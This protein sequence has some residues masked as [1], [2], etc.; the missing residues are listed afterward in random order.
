MVCVYSVR[1]TS[2]RD[3]NALEF[4]G[5]QEERLQFAKRENLVC[6]VTLFVVKSDKHAPL[7]IETVYTIGKCH[8]RQHTYTH[9]PT[10][11]HTPPP[12]H[13]PTESTVII[14]TVP[15]NQEGFHYKDVHRPRELQSSNFLG[16]LHQ[17]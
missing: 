13:P 6:Y 11:T 9:P 5:L 10:H 2:I 7:H 12:S 4:V 1:L 8:L 14:M 17:F 15:L 3:C 16:I